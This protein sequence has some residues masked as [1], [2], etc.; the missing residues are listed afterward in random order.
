MQIHMV[1]IQFHVVRYR[2]RVRWFPAQW[3]LS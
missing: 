1:D 3:L 2:N